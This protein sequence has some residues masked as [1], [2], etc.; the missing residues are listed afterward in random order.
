MNVDSGTL[1]ELGNH[2][3][4]PVQTDFAAVQ[5]ELIVVRLA[6]LGAGIEL[7]VG[8][9][10]LVLVVEPLGGRFLPLAVHRH[11]TLG[12]LLIGG[13]DKYR[14]AVCHIPQ[15]V[16]GTAA[17]DDTGLLL[18]QVGDDLLLGQ[19][20]LVRGGLSVPLPAR[21]GIVKQPVGGCVLAVFLDVFLMLVKTCKIIPPFQNN[22]YEPS[23]PLSRDIYSRVHEGTAFNASAIVPNDHWSVLGAAL[24][25][26]LADRSDRAELIDSIVAYWDEQ[27]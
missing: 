24:Q 17:H 3:D 8:L 2:V 21:H 20:H 19:P 18:G 25:K 1:I 27:Q 11:D 4:T 12:P 9:P 16:V 7:I 6:P 10:L 5:A 23:D 22:P 14:Q 15:N 26:Y 13:M